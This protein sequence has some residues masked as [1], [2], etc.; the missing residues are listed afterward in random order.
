MD[1]D[2]RFLGDWSLM[3]AVPFGLA[4]SV[5]AWRY[6][7]R[8]TR[9]R[10]DSLSWLLP[11]LRAIVV[12]LLF[13]ILT[14]PVL[15][16][17]EVVG[18][19]ARLLLL[20]DASR[21]M[22]V[23]DE[24][25]D[26]RRKLLI[27]A[28]LGWLDDS[29]VD[30]AFRA[31]SNESGR[32]S[33]AAAQAKANL[34]AVDAQ[35][36]AVELADASEAAL[37]ALEKLRD[38]NSPGL[39]DLKRSLRSDVV[40]PARKL[41]DAPP[42]RDTARLLQELRRI[43]RESDNWNARMTASFDQHVAT[44]IENGDTRLRD[45]LKKFD[46]EPRWNRVRSHLL[47]GDESLFSRLIATHEV[48]LTRMIGGESETLWIS[49]ADQ[50]DDMDALF[51]AFQV[52]TNNISTDLSST[53]RERTA[54]VEAGDNMAAVLISDGR[55]NMGDSPENL[56][57][58]LGNR[59]VK[60][61]TLSV[62]TA[63]PPEDLAIVEVD[64]PASVFH[65][66][67]AKGYIRIADN[68][69]S[70]QRFSVSIEKD[71]LIV[72][73]KELLTERNP[74]RTVPYDFPIKN[75]VGS[76]LESRDSDLKLAAVPLDFQVRI[77]EVA[78]EKDASNNQR[79]L[80][81]AAITEKP[82]MLILEGRP[83]WEFRYLRNALERDDS[84]DVNALRAGGGGEERPWR[85]GK[86][87]GTFPD[88]L[89]T[90]YSYHLIVFGDVPMTM[91]KT[92]ELQWLHSYVENRGG[93]VIFL[94]G[95][96]TPL[97]FY[98]RTPLGNL[99]PVE[100]QTGSL[101][102]RDIKLEFTASDSSAGPISLVAGAEQNKRIWASLRPPRFV[103]PARALPGSEVLM[104]ARL[105]EREADAMVF[106]RQGA[107]KVLYIGHDES[108]RWRYGIGDLYHQK[109]WNQAARW[110]MEPSFPVEDKYVALDTGPLMYKPGE[111]A[112]IRV[113]LR[114][115]EGRLILNANAE[116]QIFRNGEKVASVA[117]EADVNSGGVF[118]GQTAPL[119]EGDYEV[120]IRVDGLPEDQMKARTFFTVQAD[121]GGEMAVL[122]AN[123]ELLRNVAANSGG[124]FFR[125]EEIDQLAEQLKPLSKGQIEEFDMLL[126]QSYWWFVPIVLLL[127]LEW[128]L[129]KR[130][131][132]L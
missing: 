99:F 82:R 65:E 116:A 70:G 60:V 26:L 111:Q 89:E 113:R 19:L 73:E 13:M 69:E 107:G 14:G 21:S 62:G 17:R 130:A 35:N 34:V 119:Y 12:F 128:A 20:A 48:E 85:R 36:V 15:H 131:G 105:G 18:D 44:L 123:E 3:T 81:F 74:S 66:S 56:A 61:F 129:R 77:S 53:L 78:G 2:L 93:G 39:A 122:S 124:R 91:F 76:E 118:R 100:W 33:R 84:W 10:V 11:T 5:F 115:A 90:L 126:W 71:G 47:E 88:D 68:M 94:D 54:E 29:S 64:A 101:S 92:E 104:K 109:F 55:H 96:R 7:R 42:G 132:M 52:G 102:G 49:G 108:W 30:P 27:A 6:Y 24:Q 45:A 114:D 28:Q 86:A 32:M 8:E 106:R 83:R 58:I 97:A 67:R 110:I 112:R 80:R 38:S 31:V 40:A 22:S 103:P 125:E 95:R 37:E 79:P 75:L 9:L 16:R 41:A 43:A 4:L 1:Y 127:T 87:P 59:G 120:K 23:T 50:S 51:E 63:A 72:W 46:E 117:L 121:S 57:K 98:R 25:M